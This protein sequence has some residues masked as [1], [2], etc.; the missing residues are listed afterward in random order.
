M[1]LN[2]GDDLF[3]LLGGLAEDGRHTVLVVVQGV[4]RHLRTTHNCL[5]KN[6]EKTEIR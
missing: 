3:A 5:K 4:H 6:R 2:T 1:V